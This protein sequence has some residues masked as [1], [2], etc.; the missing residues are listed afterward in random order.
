ML[1]QSVASAFSYYN[2]PSTTETQ[3][4]VS[5]FDKFFDCMNVRSTTEWRKKKKPNLK[6]YTSIEDERLEVSFVRM[7]FRH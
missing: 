5:Y 3:K 7:Q 4:F 6:P 1:S 2:D